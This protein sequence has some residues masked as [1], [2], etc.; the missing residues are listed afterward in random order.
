MTS[1]PSFFIPMLY[2]APA[3][4]LLRQNVIVNRHTMEN[5]S[6]I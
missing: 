2:T 1:V 6:F 5:H 4:L 3:A